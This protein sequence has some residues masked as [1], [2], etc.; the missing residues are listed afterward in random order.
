MTAL[1]FPA[2]VLET[3]ATHITTNIRELEGAL[4][5]LLAHSTLN[6]REI[7]NDLARQVIDRLVR[8]SKRRYR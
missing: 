2:N 1:T 7:N 4:I 6:R 8:N 3:L 5:N